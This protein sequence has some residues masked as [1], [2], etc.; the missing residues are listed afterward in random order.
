MSEVSDAYITPNHASSLHDLRV[1]QAPNSEP[2]SATHQWSSE[3]EKKSYS[4]LFL[5]Y[6]QNKRF[7]NGISEIR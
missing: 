6:P 2:W 5:S 3:K 7:K 4:Y 1:V